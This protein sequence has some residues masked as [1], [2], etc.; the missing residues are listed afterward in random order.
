MARRHRAH[1]VQAG[2]AYYHAH[3]HDQEEPVDDAA[4]KQRHCSARRS[5]LVEA[6]E[7]C[8]Y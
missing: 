8:R 6:V 7:D 5:D 4:A 3:M 1:T 2:V